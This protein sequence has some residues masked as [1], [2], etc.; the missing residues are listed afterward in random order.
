MVAALVGEC[1]GR[2]EHLN[3]GYQTKKQEDNP[4][5]FVSFE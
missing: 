3:N 1:T 5:D 4:D 2:T